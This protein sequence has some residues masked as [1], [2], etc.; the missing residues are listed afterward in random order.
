MII[1][2]KQIKQKQNLTFILPFD[3]ETLKPDMGFLTFNFETR[4]INVTFL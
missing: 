2:I 4:I 1:V 3:F